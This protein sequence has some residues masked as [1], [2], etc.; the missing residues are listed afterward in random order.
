MTYGK[1]PSRDKYRHQSATFFGQ[2]VFDA[3]WILSEVGSF[4]QTIRLQLAQM[5]R[6]H[7][8]RNA[9]DVPYQLRRPHRRIG[10]EAK[11]DSE[12]PTALDHPHDAGHMCYGT[13]W[14]E[15]GAPA[16]GHTRHF[17]VRTC[18]RHQL[19]RPSS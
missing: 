3:R 10:E 19:N 2:S 4:D 16:L 17:K 11:E 9:G 5:L 14:T 12:L 15:T 7:L 1:V 13:V 18:L 6:E 8:L